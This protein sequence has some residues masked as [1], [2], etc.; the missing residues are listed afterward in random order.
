M[1]PDAQFHTADGLG[2]NATLVGISANEEY[3]LAK[4][5]YILFNYTTSSNATG[6]EVKT[7]V[8]E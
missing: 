8:N 6:T 7:V 1:L 5:E 4:D 3:Q 2:Q